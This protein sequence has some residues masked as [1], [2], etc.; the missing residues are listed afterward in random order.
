[1]SS[2]ELPTRSER[3]LVGRKLLYAVS[4]FAS[5]GVFLF[6]SDQGYLGYPGPIEVGTM[7]AVLEVGALVTSIAAGRIGDTVG[8]EGTLVVSGFGVGLLSYLAF[9]CGCSDFSQR[10][11]SACM[12][13]TVN[14]IGYSSSVWTDYFCSFLEFN[15][16]WRIPLFVQCVTGAILAVG[17][18]FVP[19]S[20]RWLIDTRQEATGM[21][22]IADLHGG[23]IHDPRAVAEFEEIR[24]KVCEEREFEEG[25]SYKGMWQKYKRRVLLAMSSQAFAQLIGRDAAILMTGIN[26]LVYVASAVPPWYL[27][28]RWGRRTILMSGAVIVGMVA[29]SSIGLALVA[30]EVLN[31][32]LPQ[33]PKGVVICVIIYN[34]AFGWGSVP[35]LYPPEVL[36]S[37]A[38][39]WGI[40]FVVGEVTPYL[41]EVISWRF[42]P[43]HGFFCFCSFYPVYPETRG[44]TPE[45]MGA[46]FGKDST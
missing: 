19:E 20:P 12:E 46:V 3:R 7:V 36:T 9:L 8:R 16:A 42:Y 17:S 1:M 25:R 4:I 31:V 29:F 40:N 21:R 26:S 11:A 39:N 33:T 41:Q 24:S 6:G 27:V 22:I 43:M 14:I 2:N 37:T 35:W 13:F 34:A 18:F 23:D 38:T 44:V 28:D 10:G 5:L 32:D 30:T 15:L 45:E